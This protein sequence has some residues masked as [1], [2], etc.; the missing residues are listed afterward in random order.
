MSFTETLV[1]KKAASIQVERL[2]LA[3]RKVGLLNRGWEYAQRCR[4]LFDGI[5]LIG[6]NVLE[7]GCGKGMLCLWAKA[8]GANHVV[9]L[10]P[11]QDG[12]Y[13]SPKCFRDF[14][15]VVNDLG[16]EN[17]ELLPRRIQDYGQAV[18]HF[19]VVLSIASINHLDE[20]S[21]IELQ[22]SKVAHDR[23]VAL[24]NHV[25]DL[26]TESGT[27]LVV[28]ASNRNLFGNLNLRNPFNR[29]IEWFKH[30]EP[31]CW[32][33]LLT[34]C[35]FFEPHT[36]WLAGHWLTSLGISSVPRTLSYCAWSAFR[37]RMKCAARVLTASSGRYA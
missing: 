22:K 9:G 8:Q 16:L 1:T 11:L 3:A 31:G 23:Y 13:D 26:M 29:N 15:A 2:K 20:Q 17:I 35:G 27:L 36:S 10:E 7:I 6:K 34:E 33:H 25:R 12:A 30:Q 37:L 32:A 28:D 24:F 14:N 18:S 4:V 5:D 21:C 19:D